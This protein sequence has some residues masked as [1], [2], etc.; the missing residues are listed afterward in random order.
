MGINDMLQVGTNT[1]WQVEAC[2][3]FVETGAYRAEDVAKILGNPWD[4]VQVS[5]SQPAGAGNLS[6][7]DL[8]ALIE[9]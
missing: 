7:Q 3:Y 4:S 1:T 2:S 5:A 6:A 8:S 9:G